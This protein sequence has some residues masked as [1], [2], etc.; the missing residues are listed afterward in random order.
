M[1]V[2]AC[3]IMKPPIDA[4]VKSS[5]TGAALESTPVV[6]ALLISDPDAPGVAVELPSLPEDDAEGIEPP[7]ERTCAYPAVVAPLD[8]VEATSG[9]TESSEVEPLS[10]P[11]TIVHNIST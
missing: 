4:S 8:C 10:A 6:A 5:I 1:S 11:M 3:Y 2:R 7:S 9:H